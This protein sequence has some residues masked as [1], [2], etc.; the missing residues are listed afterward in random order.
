MKIKLSKDENE[1][2]GSFERG[3]WLQNKNLTKRKKELIQYAKNTLRKDE[4]LNI[5][6][7]KRDMDAL[8]K[9]A[10]VEGLPYQTFV[11]SILHKYLNGRLTEKTS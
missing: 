3:E 2:L 7:S 11:S 6:I 5:R 10:I 1:I 4:R 9:K 8:Q